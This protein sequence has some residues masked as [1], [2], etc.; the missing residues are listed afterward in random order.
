MSSAGAGRASLAFGG[1]RAARL[2]VLTRRGDLCKPA[3]SDPADG[4]GSDW[5]GPAAW[6]QGRRVGGGRGAGLQPR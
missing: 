6:L 2:G 5:A 1:S 4:E 3:V